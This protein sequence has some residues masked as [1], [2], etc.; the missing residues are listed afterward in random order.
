MGKLGS[1]LWDGTVNGV[2]DLWGGAVSGV[3]LWVAGVAAC[4]AIWLVLAVFGFVDD[5]GSTD[6]LASKFFTAAR[7]GNYV[8]VGV[9]IWAALAAQNAQAVGGLVVVI[10][11]AIGFEALFQGRKSD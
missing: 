11:T 5:P 3:I 10:P 9:T 8:G 4:V 6:Y 2:T 1:D 7:L